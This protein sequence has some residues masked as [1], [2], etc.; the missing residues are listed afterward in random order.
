M[1]QVKRLALL[2]LQVVLGLKL[3]QVP[4]IAEVVDDP[5]R[6]LV[7]P[8]EMLLHRLDGRVLATLQQGR[9][10]IVDALF[11]ALQLADGSPLLPVSLAAD[12]RDA[13]QDHPLLPL[14]RVPLDRNRDGLAVGAERD[15]SEVGRE[16]DFVDA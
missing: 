2:L 3:N 7:V 5:P 9:H 4:P 10:G 13:I 12:S 8:P 1:V 16:P 6:L 14:V 15:L 11:F